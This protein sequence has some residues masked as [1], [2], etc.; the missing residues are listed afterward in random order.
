MKTISIF[1]QK[2]LTDKVYDY[3]EDQI[4][5]QKI[6]QGEEI[7]EITVAGDLGISVTPVR[8]AL[9]RLSGEGLVVKESNRRPRVITLTESQ[10]DELYD[11]RSSLECLAI[12]KAAQIV[13]SADISKLRQLHS[14]GQSYFLDSN[15]SKYRAYDREFHETIIKICNSK[16]IE[17]FMN[18]ISKK[19]SLCIASTVQIPDLHAIGINQH[20]EMINL[21]QEHEPEK[22][23]EKMKNHI[24]IAKEY[25][26]KVIKQKKGGD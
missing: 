22:A 15:Y 18:R 8:E 9:N 17:E 6:K 3:L 10:I 5:C 16:L 13:T 7:P 4:L 1:D 11:I 21:L 12:S 20:Q 25:Y 14:R 24:K 26:L 19:I 23:E 2:N